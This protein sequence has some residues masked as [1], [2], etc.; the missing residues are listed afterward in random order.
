M[1]IYRGGKPGAPPYFIYKFSEGRSHRV[2]RDHLRNFSGF[3]H[4]DSFSIYEQL[5]HDPGIDISWAACWS[6]ARRKFIEAEA[7]NIK[8]GKTILSIIT[9]LFRYERVAWNHDSD[10]RLQIRQEKELPLVNN[11]FDFMK[12]TVKLGRFTPSMRITTAMGYMLSREENFRLYLSN[13]D[14]RMDNNPAERSLRKVV[15]GRNNWL[16]VGSPRG[17]QA[18][19]NLLSLVQTCRAMAIDPQEYLQDVFTNFLDYPA[20]KCKDFLPDH[21]AKVRKPLLQP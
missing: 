21:W 12:N 1:W 15:V 17:G 13:P 7:G 16:F 20:K 11:L 18:A 9:N 14:L 6:H 19:A 2:P 4:A 3:I 5:H 8:E 10:T